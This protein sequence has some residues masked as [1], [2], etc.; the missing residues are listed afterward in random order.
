MS[1]LFI[2]DY[3]KNNLDSIKNFQMKV[4]ETNK[5]KKDTYTIYFE[6]NDYYAINNNDIST[7]KH[8]TMF[9][10]SDILNMRIGPNVNQI[11]LENFILS[12]I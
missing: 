3:F 8:I 12:I 6:D 1:Q 7:A 4:K 9:T 5:V 2:Q 10:V 11:E